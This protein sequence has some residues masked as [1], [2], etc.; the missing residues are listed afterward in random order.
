MH[1]LIFV[2]RINAASVTVIIIHVAR[3]IF[4]VLYAIVF[5]TVFNA[6]NVRITAWKG[7]PSTE[8]GVCF[9]IESQVLGLDAEILRQVFSCAHVLIGRCRPDF[10]RKEVYGIADR[11]QVTEDRVGYVVTEFSYCPR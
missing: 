6:R 10:G 11:L 2:R 1:I 5:T 4:S 8:H 3:F 7:S 9:R